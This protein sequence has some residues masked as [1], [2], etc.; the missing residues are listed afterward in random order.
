MV[1][2]GGGQGVG[3]GGGN[4][5]IEI[6]PSGGPLP[7]IQ[8]VARDLSIS[9][10]QVAATLTLTLT[11]NDNSLFAPGVTYRIFWLSPLIFSRDDIYGQSQAQISGQ[12]V[13]FLTGRQFVVDMS[14]GS[15]RLSTVIPYGPY[16]KGGWMYAVVIQPGNT[17]EYRLSGTNFVAVPTFGAA[18]LPLFNVQGPLVTQRGGTTKGRNLLAFWN[19]PSD[20]TTVDSVA[21][22]IQNYFAD[23]QY[24]E[25][26]TYKLTTG[27][28]MAQG[29]LG[30]VTGSS[31][32]PFSPQTFIL[33]PDSAVG[34][35][36]LTFW[37]QP[38]TPAGVPLDLSLSAS[39]AWPNPNGIV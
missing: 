23:G 1:A 21:V 20:V 17:K 24:R 33:E 15:A 31:T 6:G 11:P 27:A 18:G 28:G 12:G 38:I 9:V 26:A 5:P 13:A 14:G 3:P 2:V 7:T 37:F 25:I 30:T 22:W 29:N 10:D 4:G 34:A 35:H 32:V 36:A 39:Y 16:S 19:N 8:G